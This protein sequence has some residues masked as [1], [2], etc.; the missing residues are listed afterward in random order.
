MRFIIPFLALIVLGMAVIPAQAQQRGCNSSHEAAV[1]FLA[2][3]Y[4]EVVISMGLAS[5]GNVLEVLS[6]DSGSWSILITA[7]NGRSCLIASGQA[8]ERLPVITVGSD[9]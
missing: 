7:P 2:K 8:W 6:S 3:T 5:T 9:S 4:N 1:Q